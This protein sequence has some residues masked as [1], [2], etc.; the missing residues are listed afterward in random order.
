MELR[1]HVTQC[2][3]CPAKDE[4]RGALRRAEA[5][6]KAIYQRVTQ[7]VAWGGS[8][9]Q[10]RIVGRLMDPLNL[11]GQAAAAAAQARENALFRN[12]LATAYCF[13]VTPDESEEVACRQQFSS[14]SFDIDSAQ[15]LGTCVASPD[16]AACMDRLSIVP[17]MRREIATACNLTLQQAA[18]PSFDVMTTCV[19][20]TKARPAQTARSHIVP[21][22]TVSG[23]GISVYE[24]RNIGVDTVSIVVALE[25][26]GLYSTVTCSY[27]VPGSA[28]SEGVEFWHNSA[29]P[30]FGVIASHVER[31][32][33][34]VH[35]LG[36]F[37]LGGAAVIACP[38]THDEALRRKM[39]SSK[40]VEAYYMGSVPR[41]ARSAASQVQYLARPVRK[42]VLFQN[43]RNLLHMLE[44]N[45]EASNRLRQLVGQIPSGRDAPVLFE[46]SYAPAIIDGENFH[47]YHPGDSMFAGA[48]RFYYWHG[49]A[50]EGWEEIHAIIAADRQAVR[51]RFDA[52][53]RQSPG[54]QGNQGQPPGSPTPRLSTHQRI[55]REARDECPSTLQEAMNINRLM[56]DGEPF[57]Y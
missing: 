43:G 5:E 23:G 9:E 26:S 50:P 56:G 49:K 19:H 35:R 18:G 13:A 46:C 29:P 42:H 39:D 33:P 8:Q 55:S 25:R 45:V 3:E 27:S 30:G 7:T 28:R 17:Q 31:R 36:M 32:A 57:I 14:F 37:S 11:R 16:Q 47:R 53:R 54:E 40:A 21:F 10:A 44:G 6:E 4:L 24:G 15:V 41:S 51:S 2:G 22:N 48:A 20:P 34:D 12:N 52:I 38:P 1:A